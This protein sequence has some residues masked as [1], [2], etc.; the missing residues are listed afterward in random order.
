MSYTTVNYKTKRALKEAI[1]SGEKVTC[2]NP[3]LGPNL[4][5]ANGLVYLEGPHYPEPHKWHASGVLE[6]GILISI[7]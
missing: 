4:S 5:R 3:G 2:Y 7:N 6:N 1:A